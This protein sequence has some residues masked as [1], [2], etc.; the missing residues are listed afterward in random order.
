MDLAKGNI[1]SLAAIEKLQ[2][3]LERIESKSS[4]LGD[5]NKI[6]KGR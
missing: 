5:E 1:K 2:R 6:L 4:G 3:E